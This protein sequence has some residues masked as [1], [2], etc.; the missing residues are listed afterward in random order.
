MAV[1][2]SPAS[3][4]TLYLLPESNLLLRPKLEAQLKPGARVVSHNYSIEGWSDKKV[5]SET[6]TDEKGT[7]HTV[8]LYKR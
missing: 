1:D 7:E 2:I 4:V 5:K 3:V 8:Y 6:L